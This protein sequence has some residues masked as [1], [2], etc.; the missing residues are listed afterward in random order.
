[1]IQFFKA[2]LRKVPVLTVFASQIATCTG[3]AEPEMAGDKMV[4]RG[5]FYG[6]DIDNRR[7]SIDKSV[8]RSSLVFSVSAETPFPIAD[9]TLPRTEKTLDSFPLL[10]LIEKCFFGRRS[11][12]YHQE[13]PEINFDELIICNININ[14]QLQPTEIT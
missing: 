12:I 3:N 14:F 6:T 5:F 7:F 9:D 11:R 1:M 4:E 13:H 10:F 8:Q 2:F